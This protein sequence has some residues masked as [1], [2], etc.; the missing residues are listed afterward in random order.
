[1]RLFLVA[2]LFLFGFQ[3]QVLSKDVSSPQSPYHLIIYG[4][5]LSAGYK[6]PATDSF[7]GQLQEAL[8][9][10]GY[11]TVQ[12]INQSKSGETTAGGIRR[13]S[14]A[15]AQ[16]P[17]AVILELGINDVLMGQ[18][19]SSIENNLRKI[20]QTFKDKNIPVLLV[21]MQAP[22]VAEPAYQQQFR[23]MYETLASEYHLLFYPFFMK[24]L[25]TIEMGQINPKPTLL[26]AD[27]V[28]PT[29]EGINLIVQN[30]LPDV[31][32]LLNQNGVFP[33]TIAE[34]K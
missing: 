15:F 7:Y 25:F 11:T 23:K 12:V 17:N 27:N 1:M 24:D 5:S 3:Q 26:M 9:K 14:A 30:I 34:K 8:N 20:I 4:D 31:I 2:F 19:V 22:P 21:G 28:H 29:K 33:Q 16:K 32:R 6:L 18:S 10:K 13:L